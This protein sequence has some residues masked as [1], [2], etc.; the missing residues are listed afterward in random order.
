MGAAGDETPCR[1]HVDLGSLVE[2]RLRHGGADH[3][4]GDV[5]AQLFGR[6]PIA[7]LARHDHGIYAQR[8]APVVL[9]GDL[10]LAVGAKIGQSP[11]AADVRQR[12]DEVVRQHER[13]RHQLGSLVAGVPEHQPLVA[14]APG[15]DA[16]RDVGR[17]PVQ[18]RQHRARIGVETELR[19]R[20][21]DVP[22]RLAGDVG[23]LDPGGGGD[24]PRQHDEPGCQQ[25]LAGYASSWILRQD[26]IEDRVG[27]L[28]GNLVRM[29]FRDRFRSEEVTA[30]PAHGA[31]SLPSR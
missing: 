25:G 4:P 3:L 26:G 1:V 22:H 24:L 14:C 16:H 6:D 5:V 13:K 18:R 21:P 15:I 31:V 11:F 28:I 2:H 19:A 9:H 20:I 23:E 7:V 8:P 27:N 29:A 10:R 17:L 30:C 12:P